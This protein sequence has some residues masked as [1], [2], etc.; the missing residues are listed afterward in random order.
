MQNKSINDVNHKKNRDTSYYMRKL[1][2]FN[3]YLSTYCNFLKKY[4]PYE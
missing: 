4:N 1:K 3:L 2:Y